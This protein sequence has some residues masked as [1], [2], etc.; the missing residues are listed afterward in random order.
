MVHPMSSRS[1]K[2]CNRNSTS[3]IPIQCPIWCNE[4][5]T[6]G[7]AGDF[8]QDHHTLHISYDN[9]TGQSSTSTQKY[10]TE[11]TSST[12]CT[13]QQIYCK[14]GELLALKKVKHPH[15]G[16]TLVNRLPLIKQQTP[17]DKARHSVTLFQLL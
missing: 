1:C 14:P 8:F 3:T 13:C 12:L 16:K 15:N 17:I 11:W 6:D 7:T 5:S 2:I 9:K 10:F 4:F